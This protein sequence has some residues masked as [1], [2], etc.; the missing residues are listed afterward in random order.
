MDSINRVLAALALL[1]IIAFFAVGTFHYW[2]H[3]DL[4]PSE[5]DA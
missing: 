3:R 1:A 5:V 2:R 4:F